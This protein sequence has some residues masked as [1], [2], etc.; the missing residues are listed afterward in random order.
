MSFIRTKKIHGR[1]YLYEVE[2]YR[3][4][5]KVR[6]RVLRYIG[7]ASD[8]IPVVPRIKKEKKPKVKITVVPKL[9]KIIM[10]PFNQPAPESHG[11]KSFTDDFLKIGTRNPMDPRSI[12]MNN[13]DVTVQLMPFEGKVDF[14]IST[15]GTRKAGSGTRVMRQLIEL[16][17]K[18]GVILSGDIK[19]FGKAKG[20]SKAQLKKW[21]QTF[22][23]VVKNG[24]HIERAPVAKVATNTEVQIGSV[25]TPEKKNFDDKVLAVLQK[26]EYLGHGGVDE[27]EIASSIFPWDGAG[28][29][30]KHG[31]W[32]R[33]VVQAGYR[34][35]QKGLAGNFM[36]LHHPPGHNGPESRVWFANKV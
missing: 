5:D 7:P 19:P 16:A 30:S 4:G 31:A 21:Y 23:F 2:N 8:N 12:V 27:W 28:M 11:I 34:L 35:Q 32:I 9:K 36:V 24:D 3:E 6:Q 29:R 22:G 1:K 18:H 26:P 10:V 14:N 15:F 25:Q 13:E 20:M 33:A 17:D